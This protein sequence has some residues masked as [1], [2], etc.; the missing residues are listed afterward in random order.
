MDTLDAGSVSGTLGA[1]K[2][3]SSVMTSIIRRTIGIVLLLLGLAHLVWTSLVSCID[4]GSVTLMLSR[5]D[6]SLSSTIRTFSFT[7]WLTTKLFYVRPFAYKDLDFSTSTIQ[8][9]R[10]GVSPHWLIWRTY[11]EAEYRKPDGSVT[12]GPAG[13]IIPYSAPNVFVSLPILAVA[14]FFLRGRGR[15]PNKSAAPNGGPPTPLGDS[16]IPEGPPSVS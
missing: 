12:I 15:A 6:G 1:E 11:Y 14:F 13:G 16:V 9:Y 8:R 10:V 2:S 3:V 4:T 5:A 7:P